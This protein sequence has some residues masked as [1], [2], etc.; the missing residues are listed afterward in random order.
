MKIDHILITSDLS[1]ESL[2]HAPTV[3]DLARAMGA[4]VTLMHVAEELRIAPHGAPLAPPISPP[5][6]HKR[7]AEAKTALEEARSAFGADIEVAIE[8]IT[9]EKVAPGVADWAE[10]HDVDLLCIS[11]HGRTGFRHLALGSVAEA[12][13]RHSTVPVLSFP[14]AKP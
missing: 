6:T 14:Q 5:D 8:V 12:I 13:I 9:A 2:Q 10:N 4:R 3:A 7:I 11:T 1:Q